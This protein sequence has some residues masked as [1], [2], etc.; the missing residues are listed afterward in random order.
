[1]DCFL[2]IRLKVKG[3]SA[4]VT[5]EKVY[6]FIGFMVLDVKIERL[7]AQSLR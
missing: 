6:K 4:K 1:M 7:Q 3:A 5:Q 2:W